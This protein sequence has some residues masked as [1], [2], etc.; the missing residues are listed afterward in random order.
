MPL[1]TNVSIK[2]RMLSQL[3]LK[4]VFDDQ[5]CNDIFVTK[6]DLGHENLTH[7]NRTAPSA[8]VSQAVSP[9]KLAFQS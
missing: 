6:L 2:N 5:Y 1:G 8:T 7:L 4:N 9:P 3:G